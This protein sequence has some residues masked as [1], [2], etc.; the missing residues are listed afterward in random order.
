MLINCPGLINIL[1]LYLEKSQFLRQLSKCKEVFC[2]FLHQLALVGQ[3]QTS[4]VIWT[5]IFQ[6]SLSLRFL[7]NWSNAPLSA[8]IHLARYLGL[9]LWHWVFRF[10]RSGNEML[11]ISYKVIR[12]T[13]LIAVMKTV[14]TH[15]SG[16]SNNDNKDSNRSLLFALPLVSNGNYH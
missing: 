16:S 14:K 5:I 7:H 15:L 2:L 6:S 4:Q 8:G 12:N 3:R 11:R 10:W 13:V 1:Q 9:I